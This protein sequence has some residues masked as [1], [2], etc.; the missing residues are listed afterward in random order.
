MKFLG[1][2]SSELSCQVF[3]LGSVL[4]Y[5]SYLQYIL[6]W[7][8][9]SISQ[10]FCSTSMIRNKGLIRNYSIFF[11]QVVTKIVEARAIFV[12]LWWPICTVH[13]LTQITKQLH[14]QCGK[15]EEEKHEEQ[16]Q[17]SHLQQRQQEEAGLVREIYQDKKSP[18]EMTKQLILEKDKTE[19]PGLGLCQLYII[20]RVCIHGRGF[21][22]EL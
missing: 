9:S 20:W 3:Y 21:P 12:I 13:V 5:R 4:I 22:N 19:K 10:C 14:S 15:D 18:R 11:L 7:K 17:I 1:L 16:T 2:H 8:S 6:Q